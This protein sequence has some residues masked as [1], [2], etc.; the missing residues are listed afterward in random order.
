ML[1]QSKRIQSVV[2]LLVSAI[3]FLN[4]LPPVASWSV[5]TPRLKRPKLYAPTFKRGPK[6]PTNPVTK[7][8]VINNVLL[9][10]PV[11]N[12]KQQPGATV[13]LQLPPRISMPPARPPPAVSS[14]ITTTT[15]TGV[16]EQTYNNKDE[17]I[18]TSQEEPPFVVATNGILNSATA[19]TLSL[20]A[21]FVPPDTT[22]T[23][24]QAAKVVLSSFP[25]TS[26]Q[27]DLRDI[28]LL[29]GMIS[30]TWAKVAPL[31]TTTI[32]QPSSIVVSSPTDKFGAIRNFLD[33]GRLEFDVGGLITTHLDVDVEPNDQGGFAQIRLSSKLIPKWPF[34]RTD[35]K[36]KWNRV[37]NM[38]NGETYYFDSVS[39]ETQY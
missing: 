35:A 30:G 11:K 26:I 12:G 28:P 8:G 17:M 2:V 24:D 19:A 34:G 22:A 21:S 4:L 27:L 10:N 1:C 15:T 39:G 5:P 16:P 3:L 23:S 36:S 20:M 7:N 29:G 6:Q 14:M 31:Q 25:P 18:L 38:G 37:T 33:R 13:P 9:D 32:K